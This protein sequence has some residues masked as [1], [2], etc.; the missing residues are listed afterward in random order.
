MK[1]TIRDKTE[2]QLV[3]DVKG[4]EPPLANA[5]RRIMISEIASVAIEKVNMW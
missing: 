4:I 3:F 1:V 5:L 2:E